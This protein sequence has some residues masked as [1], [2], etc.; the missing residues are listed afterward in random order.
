[1][2]LPELLKHAEEIVGEPIQI[3]LERPALPGAIRIR[4][5]TQRPSGTTDLATTAIVDAID[6]QRYRGD[7]IEYTLN[8]L[9]LSMRHA[10]DHN[11]L[12]K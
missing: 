4:V 2:T 5:S 11:K 7:L 1:M 3:S 9:L 12:I 6:A 10:V 8:R